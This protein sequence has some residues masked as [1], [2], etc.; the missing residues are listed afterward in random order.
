MTAGS[1]PGPANFFPRIAETDSDYIYS[2][3]TSD[4]RVND[5]YIQK[6]QSVRRKILSGV[7]IKD[8]NMDRRTGS[9]YLTKLMLKNGI[10]HNTINQY[11]DQ[12]VFLLIIASL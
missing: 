1:I 12:S 8:T 5:R 6:K 9:L 7:L 3:L 10:T 2:Y 11:I 4:H